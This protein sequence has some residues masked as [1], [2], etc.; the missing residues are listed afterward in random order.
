MKLKQIPK[1]LLKSRKTIAV[2]ESCTG[3]LIS[4]ALTNVSGSSN[5]F[6]LGLILYSDNAK[7]KILKIRKADISRFGSVSKEIA[8]LMAKKVKSLTKTDIGLATTGFAGPKGGNINNPIGTV[9]IAL[10]YK[11]SVTV[12][13]LKFIGKRIQI[14]NKAKNK[15]LSLIKECLLNP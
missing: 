13:K 15:A 11:N 2:A 1:L 6:K 12:K 7:S 10:A 3:G 4:H 9:Y 14:K 5:Y 8:I